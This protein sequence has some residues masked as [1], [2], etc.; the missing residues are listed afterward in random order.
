MSGR[1]STIKRCIDVVNGKADSMYDDVKDVVNRLPA[2]FMIR[3]D[4]LDSS[5][6]AG[7]VYIMSGAIQG[8][9]PIETEIYEFNSTEAA[10]QY[11]KALYNESTTSD[12]KRDGI[13][14]TIVTLHPEGFK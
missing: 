14:V 7:Y 4:A 6:H 8:D 9:N 12:V 2:S 1:D 5:S 11:T 10:Q 3:I 13:F